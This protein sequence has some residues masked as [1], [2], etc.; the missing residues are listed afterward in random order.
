MKVA[1][2]SSLANML[3]KTLLRKL[4]LSNPDVAQREG[5]QQRH[6]GLLT[7]GSVSK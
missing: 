2:G 5:K 3:L 1:Q 6:H 7:A 4:V